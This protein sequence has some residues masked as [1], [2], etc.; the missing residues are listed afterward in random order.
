MKWEYLT[1]HGDWISTPETEKS[2]RR[3]NEL[4]NEGW[5]LVAITGDH[6]GD[7]RWKTSIFKRPRSN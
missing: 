6:A 5:E 7:A 1:V 3:L 2:R 4:G